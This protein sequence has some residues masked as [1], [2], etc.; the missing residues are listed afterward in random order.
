VEF[1][2]YQDLKYSLAGMITDQSFAEITK[3]YFMAILAYRMAKIFQ[4]NPST[5]MVKLSQ[6]DLAFDDRKRADRF[7][8]EAWLQHLG[9]NDKA[10]AYKELRSESHHKS[11]SSEAK[12]FLE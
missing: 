6:S 1:A 10:F 3:G 5:E 7:I 4:K 8:N 9:V 11:V 2:L 12:T